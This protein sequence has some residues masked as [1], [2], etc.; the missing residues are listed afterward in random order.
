M[1]RTQ[2]EKTRPQYTYSPVRESEARAKVR[3]ANKEKPS[4]HQPA[5]GWGSTAVSLDEAVPKSTPGVAGGSRRLQRGSESSAGTWGIY[6]NLPGRQTG[7]GSSE[8]SG[9]TD[10]TKPWGPEGI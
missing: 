4:E 9:E 3:E 2:H 8:E 10:F 7:V 1:L 6:R 5:G